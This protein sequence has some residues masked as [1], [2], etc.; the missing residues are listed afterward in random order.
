MK[1]ALLL[2]FLVLFCVQGLV[3][4]RRITVKM[5]SPIPENSPWGQSLNEIAREWERITNGL[6]E[7]IIYHSG[8]AGNENT[9]VRNL[10]LN[11][12]QAAVLS[13]FGMYEISPEI[14]TL[15]VPFLIRNDD[16][17]DA[18]LT[19]IKPE[20]EER[21]NRQGF[22]TLAWARVGWV[23][24]FS[25]APVFTPDDLKRQRLGTN[26]E[27]HELNQTFRTMGFQMIPVART[28]ILRS[29]SQ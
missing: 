10:R 7:V 13:T 11:Q 15:S 5:A 29:L 24:V 16:E 26:G 18:V 25:R 2:G 23:K 21:I 17:L 27:Q 12:I 19:G 3:A 22:F 4:Q 9:I 14:M 8:M 28:E 1:K 6:I 20:M